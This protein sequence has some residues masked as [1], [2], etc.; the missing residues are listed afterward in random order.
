MSNYLNTE[1]G[2]YPRHDGDIQLLNP[3][4]V[5][6]EPLPEPWVEVE[7]TPAP[8]VSFYET[9]D[10]VAPVY[11]KTKWIRAWNIRAMTDYEKLRKDNPYPTLPSPLGYYWDDK[12]ISWVEVTP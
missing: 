2:E 6:G 4:W 12:T 8:E 9:Y 10:E 5:N 7:E 3:N 1:T 11:E